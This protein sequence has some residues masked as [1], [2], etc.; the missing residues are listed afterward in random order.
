MGNTSEEIFCKGGQRTGVAAVGWFGQGLEGSTMLA[1]WWEWPSKREE[2]G[3]NENDQAKRE[4]GKKWMQR[5]VTDAVKQANQKTPEWG[6]RG[7]ELLHERKDWP[8]AQLQEKRVTVRRAKAEAKRIDSGTVLSLVI[9][10]WGRAV[11]LPWR[12]QWWKQ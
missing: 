11:L 8:Y 5:V 4:T 7:C 1:C 10:K 9:W 2:K 12:S 3:R 6:D